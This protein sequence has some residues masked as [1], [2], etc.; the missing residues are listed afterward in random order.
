MA[1]YWLGSLARATM[2]TYCETILQIPEL[3]P[4]SAKQLA[5][6]IDYLANVM[7]TLGLQ[8]YKALQNT[9]TL[10]KTKPEDY[11][12]VAKSFPRRLASTIASMRGLDY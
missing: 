10:L 9:V 2:Q 6:D 5:T 3:S 7:D 11:K 4:Y 8:P 1:D 12:Q